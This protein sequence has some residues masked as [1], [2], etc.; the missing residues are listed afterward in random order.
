MSCKI[1]ASKLGK[2]SVNSSSTGNGISASSESSLVSVL[3]SSVR[4]MK[5]AIRSIDSSLFSH[6]RSARTS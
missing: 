2:C 3:S 5:N 1:T 6:I 4:K